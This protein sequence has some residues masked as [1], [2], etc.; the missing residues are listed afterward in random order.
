[1]TKA[2]IFMKFLSDFF[3]IS[4]AYGKHNNFFKNYCENHYFGKLAKIALKKGTIA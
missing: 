1:M 4:H 2:P 3:L